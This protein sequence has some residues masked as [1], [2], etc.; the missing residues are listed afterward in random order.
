MKAKRHEKSRPARGGFAG[1]ANDAR[2][3]RRHHHHDLAAFHFRKLLDLGDFLEI[4]LHAFQKVGAAI[5]VGFLSV[6]MPIPLP[7]S[8]SL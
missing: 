4:V 8:V 1:V 3:A 2:L 5:L 6:W 7:S